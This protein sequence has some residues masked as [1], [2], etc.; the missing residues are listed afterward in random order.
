MNPKLQ[1]IIDII[2]RA[3]KLDTDQKNNLLECVKAVDKELE[4][5][6]FKLERTEKAKKTTDILLEET[7]VFTNY[8]SVDE[9]VKSF[10]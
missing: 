1:S 9:A 10:D 6:A 5:T 2:Q 7:I 4:L 8:N 3:E